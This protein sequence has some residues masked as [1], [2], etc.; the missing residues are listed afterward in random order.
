MAM[1]LPRGYTP[2]PAPTAIVVR[3]RPGCLLQLLWFVF[4]DWW[5]G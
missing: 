3:E 5:L 2:T 1:K 4:V